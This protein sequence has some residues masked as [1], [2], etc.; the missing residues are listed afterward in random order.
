MVAAVRLLTRFSLG[1]WMAVVSVVLV[2]G[3]L[4]L[5]GVHLLIPAVLAGVAVVVTAVKRA[6]D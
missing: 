1:W 4:V 2:A 6:A 3:L 5:A